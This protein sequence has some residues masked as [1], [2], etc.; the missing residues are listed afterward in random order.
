[1]ILPAHNAH[2]TGIYQRGSAVDFDEP[3]GAATVKWEG[4]CEAYVSE[5]QYENVSGG[6]LDIITETV[7]RV[8]GNVPAT[9]DPEDLVTFVPTGGQASTRRVRQ[10]EALQIGTLRL[11]LWST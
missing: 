10:V 8:P 6:N 7:L 3:E 5:R 4:D 11:R 2:L 1:M 9:V